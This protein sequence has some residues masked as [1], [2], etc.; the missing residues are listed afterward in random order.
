[1][2]RI[3][4]RTFPMAFA[5]TGPCLMLASNCTCSVELSSWA[6]ASRASAG[7]ACI[8]S[9]RG[10]STARSQFAG[11]MAKVIAAE[12]Q[13]QKR[14]SCDALAKHQGITMPMLRNSSKLV[15]K[16]PRNCEG[17]IS[18]AC[19]DEATMP[20]HR[21]I[22]WRDR[23]NMM[24]EK[25]PE[26]AHTIE[27]AVMV[28]AAIISERRRPNRSANH[29]AAGLR[30]AIMMA[31]FP[32]TMPSYNGEMLKART[33]ELTVAFESPIV[34]PYAS[35]LKAKYTAQ[36]INAGG[37]VSG[38]ALGSG[39]DWASKL[40]GDAFGPGEDCSSKLGCGAFGVGEHL[41]SKLG[42]ED[43]CSFLKQACMC[44]K[45]QTPPS[46][47]TKPTV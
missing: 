18:A 30:R 36:R 13:M 20:R 9:Q 45:A 14:Q 25:V 32:T 28:K 6:A 46:A 5:S 4:L 7:E 26:E 15:P 8:R 16:A 29:P 34:K 24:A 33:I 2:P 41:A 10:D 17:A 1:M 40:P 44:E 31:G 23:P 38:G 47:T 11:T 39:E 3:R 22:P 43:N 37:K 12:T 35:C 27:P 21:P 19:S 42:G